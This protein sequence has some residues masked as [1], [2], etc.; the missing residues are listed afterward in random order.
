MSSIE[1]IYNIAIKLKA[2]DIHIHSDK[3]PSLRVDGRLY[4]MDE[5]PVFTEGELNQLVDD[6]L[7]Q[8]QKEELVRKHQVDTSIDFGENGT[9]RVHIF[10][11]R[12]KLAM[13]NRIIGLS[14]IFGREGLDISSRN[15]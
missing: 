4:I 10:R 6:L 11:Q 1:R 3:Q 8:E 14:Y 2:S 7:R 9:L 13:A 5:E 15:N 12:G